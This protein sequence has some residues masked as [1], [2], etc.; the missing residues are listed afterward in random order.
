M[1]VTQELKKDQMY[2]RLELKSAEETFSTEIVNGTNTILRPANLQRVLK[3]T[4][5][6]TS[7]S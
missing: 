7:A 4:P 1:I 2:Q 3:D 5:A 6:D